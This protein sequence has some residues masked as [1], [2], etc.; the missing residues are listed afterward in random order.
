M[1]AEPAV[2]MRVRQPEP[3]A[4][5][6]LPQLGEETHT[7]GTRRDEVTAM[8]FYSYRIMVRDVDFVHILLCGRLFH[9]Y[10]V[11][12][13]AKIESGRLDYLRMQSYK[14]VQDLIHGDAAQG[15]GKV[16]KR[17]VLPANF[18]GSNRW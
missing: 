6:E 7:P 5:A 17:I 18:V 10:L 16:G 15:Y 12:E 1:Q 14:E 8:R 13:W 11:D 9:Q 3:R 2:E 4:A